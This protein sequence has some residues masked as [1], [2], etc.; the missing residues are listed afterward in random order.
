MRFE[1]NRES[2]RDIELVGSGEFIQQTK[3]ALDLLGSTTYLPMVQ[4]YL[5]RIKS[6]QRS[7]AWA[8]LNKPTFEV[9]YPTWRPCV[10]WYAGAIV[11]DAV[12]CR[13]YAQNKRKFLF[14]DFTKVRDWCGTKAELICLYAQLNAL[15]QM[16]AN[17]ELVEHVLQTIKQPTYHLIP[18]SLRHW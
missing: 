4:Y 6:G 10:Y 1:A 2:Y 9:G 17:V 3:N 5:P 12:H 16:G 15:E 8:W 7:G 13:L 14:L 18:Y 11:H